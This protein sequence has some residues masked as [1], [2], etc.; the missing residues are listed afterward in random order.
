MKFYD[1]KDLT[2]EEKYEASIE[3]LQEANYAK[4]HSLHKLKTIAFPRDSMELRNLL[5]N[6]GEYVNVFL[7]DNERGKNLFYVS[8]GDSGLLSY[9]DIYLHIER[10]T[11][12]SLVYKYDLQVEEQHD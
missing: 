4:V 9:V 2:M 10:G 6:V 7:T 3:A 5:D 12:D 8:M 11:L 1:L